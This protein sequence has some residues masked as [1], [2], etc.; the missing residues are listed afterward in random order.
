[1][2]KILLML[3]LSVFSSLS[4]Q[5][6]AE[7]DC[8][9]VILGGGVGALTSALYLSRAGI[10]VVVI[11]GPVP[12]GIITQSHFVENWPGELGISGI[13]L[14]EKIKAQVQT[15]GADLRLETVVA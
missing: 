2:K 9:T 15:S 1:M 14:I 12:G 4:A 10:P 7:E 5:H 11:L 6:E 8:Q 13:D 3:M